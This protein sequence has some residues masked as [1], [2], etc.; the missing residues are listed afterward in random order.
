MHGI[1]E[2]LIVAPICHFQELRR[3]SSSKSH[4]RVR[5]VRRVAARNTFDKGSCE[6]HVGISKMGGSAVCTPHSIVF[7]MEI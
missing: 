1:C 3:L 6:H 5:R 7:G 4:T 2:S